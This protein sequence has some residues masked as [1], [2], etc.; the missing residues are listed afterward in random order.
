MSVLRRLSKKTNTGGSDSPRASSDLSPI[1]SQSPAPHRRSLAQF[2]HL[3]D[4][5]YSTSSDNESDFSDLDSD[6]LSKK[7]QKRA[8]AKQKKNE[9]RSRLSLEHRDDSSERSKQRLEEAA[10]TE[11][12]EMKA[13][14]GD[15][16]LMQSTTR[17]TTDRIEISTITEEMAGQEIT[18]RCRLH[19]VRRMGAKLVFLVFRQ[20]LSTIQGVLVEQPG[21][22]SA[23]MIHWA[24]HQRTGNVLLVKGVL[25]KPEIPVKSASI[26]N[27]EVKVTNLHVIVRRAE[28]GT[29]P[30][31]FRIIGAS[32]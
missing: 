3:G 16:P 27:L 2:L 5:D 1:P 4:R 10:K 28:P 32:Y 14:Y 19:N 12:E 23:L 9:Q 7:A 30:C 31:F 20:Q 29:Y 18:F 13:R 25:Q 15:L 26:H 11:T 17:H 6:G 22:I 8:L 21:R 24:E